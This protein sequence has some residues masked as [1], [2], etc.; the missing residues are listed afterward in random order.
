MGRKVRQLREAQGWNQSQLADELGVS[1]RTVENLETTG[2]ASLETCKYIAN[3]FTIEL[4]GLTAL[5]EAPSDDASPVPATEGVSEYLQRFR[6]TFGIRLGPLVELR[7]LGREASLTQNLEDALLSGRNA[8]VLGRAGTGKSHAV[9]HVAL[10]LCSKSRLPIVA[11]ARHFGGDIKQ[12]LENAVSPFTLLSFD[13]LAA[14]ARAAGVPLVLVL[15][16]FNEARTL[17]E[18]LVDGLQ[19]LLL[20]FPNIGVVTTSQ[21]APPL[22]PSISGDTIEV[23]ACDTRE[24]IAILGAHGLTVHNSRDVAE[25]IEAIQSPFDLSL[26]AR[27][28]SNLPAAPTRYQ[29][30]HAFV[31]KVLEEANLDSSAITFLCEVAE[32]MSSTLIYSLDLPEAYRLWPEAAAGG[33]HGLQFLLR[34]PLLRAE[35]GRCV[36]AH[37]LMMSFFAAERLLRSTA[38][39]PALAERL[40]TARARPM[41]ALIIEAQSTDGAVRALLERSPAARSLFSAID[42]GAHGRLAQDVLR[43]DLTAVLDAC[44]RALSDTKVEISRHELPDT[45]RKT[46]VARVDYP[47]RPS[48][49][50]SGLLFFLGA[51]ASLDQWLEPVLSL[52]K[53]FDRFLK[54]EAARVCQVQKLRV[55]SVE[56]ALYNSVLHL[57]GEGNLL[58]RDLIHGIG[59]RSGFSTPP[60][61]CL[62]EWFERAAELGPGALEALCNFGHRCEVDEVV[63][64]AIAGRLPLVLQAAWNSRWIYG[65]IEALVLTDRFAS[66]AEA[67]QRRAILHTLQGL[68]TQNDPFVN[69]FWLEAMEA[70]GGKLE[71]AYSPKSVADEIRAILSSPDDDQSQQRANGIYC[72]QFESLSAISG[73]YQEA[74]GGLGE[75]ELRRF[76]ALAALGLQN[77][78]AW[79]MDLCLQSM[80]ALPVAADD[81]FVRR[82]LERW[83]AP[84]S[85]EC[86]SPQD[87]AAA[88]LQAH[89]GLAFL[90]LP[91]RGPTGPTTLRD[92]AWVRF[93]QLIY[94]AVRGSQADAPSDVQSRADE[95]WR[96]LGTNLLAESVAPF[97]LLLDVGNVR[98]KLAPHVP[99][100]EQV[101]PARIG[102]LALEILERVDIGTRA[103]FFD[104]TGSYLVRSAA[105]FGGPG[106]R[107]RLAG[108]IDHPSLGHEVLAAIRRLDGRPETGRGVT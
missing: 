76:L 22:P 79:C 50:Q 40:E 44:E 95:C 15:D 1:L 94:L 32:R 9:L 29:L 3:A 11:Q 10:R 64:K 90:A 20:R 105:S 81:P 8:T 101:W 48:A 66:R 56:C 98:P 49:Y 87:E 107:R 13:T 23:A 5:R 21:S 54:G 85:E 6:E 99:R 39:L 70:C 84:P 91:D 18:P 72:G 68:D 53:Q 36:F 108:L 24:R 17:Q 7:A 34:G 31:R 57:S 43:Q 52:L 71:S 35:R 37:E 14:T 88:F 61:H 16:G 93:G 77:L 83:A 74:I 41:A 58:I 65:R 89:A 69:T 27:C 26:A 75:H 59:N 45:G 38:D 55:E 80:V 51:Q 104:R 30:I 2:H 63:E 106:A 100:L 78:S 103:P 12:F 102:S 46:L 60:V 96:D 25:V 97:A 62:G 42:S 19:A 86:L 28:W 73:P 82:A 4:G 33:S 67:A 47:W 92:L